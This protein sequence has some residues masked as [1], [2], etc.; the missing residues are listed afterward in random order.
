[1]SVCRDRTLALAA[2]LT[3]TEYT[4]QAHPDFSPIGWHLG[5]IAYT[6]SLW[7]LEQLAKKPCGFPQYRLLFAADGLP[8]A[9]RQKLPPLAVIL[10]YLETVR[11]QVWAYLEQA[12]LDEQSRLWWWLLQHESQHAETICI[13]LALHRQPCPEDPGF[14]TSLTLPSTMIYLPAATITLGD[15][16]LDANDNEQPV[17]TAQVQGF[18][19]DTYPVTQG[20]YREFIVA[21]GY[22]TRH[23]WSAAGWDWLSQLPVKIPR[24][25]R[26]APGWEA[27]PVCGVSWYEADAYARF[28]GKRLP[29]ES[30]WERAACWNL[31]GTMHYRYP[32]GAVLDPGYCNAAQMVGCTTPVGTYGLGASDLGLQ[33]LIGNVWEWT[34]SW[35]EEYAGFSPWPYAGYSQ[36]YFDQTHRVLRGGSWATLCWSLRGTLRNWYYPQIREIFAGFRCARSA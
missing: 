18:W 21:G 16:S 1:M 6:E 15:G 22:Q 5:H 36:A 17:H 27:H 9:E 33:D 30:E 2:N 34:G 28:V 20:Q 35:F 10:D 24:Y 19:L 29:T 23:W 13:V 26:E 14:P 31:D 11:Q 3:E 32:W 12:P 7:L 25:W 8:K 4:A